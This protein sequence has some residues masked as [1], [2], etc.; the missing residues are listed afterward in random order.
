MVVG[1]GKIKAN[2]DY[3]LEKPIPQGA[4]GGKDLFAIAACQ[5]RVRGRPIFDVDSEGSGH[6]EGLVVGFR[7]QCH[8]EVE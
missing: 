3:A 4:V 2:S 1:S 8:D 7:R 6:F 5:G